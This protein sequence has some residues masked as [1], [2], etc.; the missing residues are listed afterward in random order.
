MDNQDSYLDYDEQEKER[1]ITI[2]SKNAQFTY[3]DSRISLLDTPGHTDFGGEMERVL[4]GLD[5]AV[6]VINGQNGVQSHTKTIWGLL[7]NYELPAFLFVNKMDITSL[8]KEEL[9]KNLEEHLDKNC[10]DFTMEEEELYERLAF[11]DEEVMEE[12]LSTSAVSLKT[13]QDRIAAR[14]IF[15]VY[16]GSALKDQ[17][18]EAL[19][20]GLDTLSEEKSYGDGLGLRIYKISYDEG[21]NRLCY[22]KI[23]GGCLKA[24]EKLSED[25]KIDQLFR[26][27]GR[28]F[29]LVN[30]AE[31]GDIVAIKGL[32]SHYAND[33]LGKEKGVIE[34]KLMA[35]MHYRLL[36]ERSTDTNALMKELRKLEEEYP[37]IK[38]SFDSYSSDIYLELIG[39]LQID[40]LKRILKKRM[41]I[42]ISFDEGNVLYKETIAAPSVGVGHYEPLRHYAEVHLYLEPLKRN[43]GLE[44]VSELSTDE[45]ALNWQ[46]LI[47]THLKEREHFG[48]L[49]RSPITDMRISLKAG[50]AHLKHTEGGDFREATYR[51][52]RNGLKLAES[53]LLEPYYDFLIEVEHAY[54]S[55][56][57]YDLESLNAKFRVNDLGT[58]CSIEGEGPVVNLRNY[59][60]RLAALTGGSG[61]VFLSLQGYK[62]C[63]NA[64]EVIAAIGYDSESDYSHPTGSVFCAHGAG[65]YVPYNYVRD[66]MHIKEDSRGYTSLPSVNK[67]T[68]SQ[69]ELKRV[70]ANVNG[71]NRKKEKVREREKKEEERK[72]KVVIKEKK[73]ELLIVDGYNIMRSFEKTKDLSESNF[74]MARD[75]IVAEMANY[76]GY[77]NCE[78]VIVFDAYKVEGG[79]GSIL[80]QDQVT[81][82]YTRQNQTADAY[83]EKAVY[84]YSGKY[85][86]IVATSDYAVQNSIFMNGGRRIS[87]RE[88]ENELEFL[89]TAGN[90]RRQS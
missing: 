90:N 51:A 53:I 5:G 54:L 27:N 45:L 77:K 39:D 82:V 89:K 67:N 79:L 20:D 61:S 28:K 59:Q 44:F 41:N 47:L 46:R 9:L 3:K 16:F 55:K 73:P 25:E 34:Q 74:D 85:S 26:M 71:Q 48:V 4:Q 81:V 36:Y 63:H 75:I 17:G 65:F 2:Y 86:I 13:I 38:V 56:V 7:E 50:K 43:S 10:I 78:V 72:E 14:K 52:V 83:I 64:D 24:K 32:S 22:G 6:I 60:S 84:D 57:L 15:P 29:E 18:V 11:V 62:E 58:S 33:V 8:K 69:E 42:D 31:A 80:K 35:Y 30:A 49:T 40:V 12:Y 19:L 88:L 23:T 21:G 37:E 87:A 76:A 66:Y 1:G 70:F 68:I